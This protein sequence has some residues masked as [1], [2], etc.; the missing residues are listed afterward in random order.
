MPRG[1]GAPSLGAG[2]NRSPEPAGDARRTA[3]CEA[4]SRL[5]TGRITPLIGALSITCRIGLGQ[6]QS[7]EVFR[8]SSATT[9][10]PLGPGS[11]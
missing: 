9:P 4:R 6:R 5:A 8:G 3:V 10:R 11:P 2:M 1:K 7:A